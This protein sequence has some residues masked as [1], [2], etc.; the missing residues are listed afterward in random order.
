LILRFDIRQSA[1]LSTLGEG[2]AMRIITLL[3]LM[4]SSLSFGTSCS[5]ADSSARLPNVYTHP[6]GATFR[7]PGNWKLN[8][9]KAVSDGVIVLLP[10]DAAADQELYLVAGAEAGDVKSVRDP[11]LLQAIET[12]V[13]ELAPGLRRVGDV[14]DL[15]AGKRAGVTATWQGTGADGRTA[16]VRVF[17][18]ILDRTAVSLVAIGMPARIEA[19][20]TTLRAIFGT[21]DVSTQASPAAG[22]PVAGKAAALVGIWKNWEYK[23]VGNS[24]W[25]KTTFAALRADGSFILSD[26]SESAHSFTYKDAGGNETGRAGVASQGASPATS[27]RWTAAGGRLVLQYQNGGKDDYGYQ[28][29]PNSSGY[30]ILYLQKA[31]GKTT[32]WMKVQ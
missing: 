5:R 25:E 18:T 23:A 26:S 12:R 7:Y 8:D 32:E 30:P 10:D 13:Q 31:G 24:S 3:A 27:G 11:G 16:Q 2:Y 20:A 19:R 9:T 1:V 15:S 6:Q 28:I 22:A 21:F 4:F 29:R 17:T 14:T